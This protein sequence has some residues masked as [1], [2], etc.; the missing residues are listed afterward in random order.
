MIGCCAI[1]GPKTFTVNDFFSPMAEKDRTD[2]SIV[3][4]TGVGM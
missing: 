2:G 3:T 1:F 4:V